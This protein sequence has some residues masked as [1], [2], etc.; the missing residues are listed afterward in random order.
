[1][2]KGSRSSNTTVAKSIPS[3]QILASNIILQQKEQRFLGKMA[4]SKMG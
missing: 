4:S 3:A 2:L 1:M